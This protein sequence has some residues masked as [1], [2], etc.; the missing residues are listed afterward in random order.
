MALDRLRRELGLDFLLDGSVRRSP[1]GARIAVE[2]VDVKEQTLVWAEAYERSFTDL[3]GIQ[4]DRCDT[5]GSI[6]C[7]WNYCLAG[8]RARTENSDQFAGT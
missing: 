7:V 1:D 4:S 6:T 8:C 3:Y 2:L 5:C